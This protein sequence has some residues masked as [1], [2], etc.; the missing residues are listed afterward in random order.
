[1]SYEALVNAANALDAAA[2]S[3]QQIISQL[4]SVRNEMTGE[5]LIGSAGH[6]ASLNLENT[7]GRL[8]V[9]INR[10]NELRAALQATLQDMQSDVD[11]G[12]AARFD[13]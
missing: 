3:Y 10:A 9:M 5:W 6:Y 1:M 7:Q 13:N 8:R 12:M 11:P 2:Q 4:Q